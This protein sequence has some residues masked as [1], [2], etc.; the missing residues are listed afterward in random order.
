MAD[1]S[2]MGPGMTGPP[3][4]TASIGQRHI[5]AEALTARRDAA[6]LPRGTERGTDRV[7]LSDHARFLDQLGRMPAVRS[8]RVDEI[9]KAIAD[10]SYETEHRLMTALERLAQELQ[11]E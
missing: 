3:D 9:R 8:E 11:D 7:E 4:R 6:S 10:G 2:P 5:A 1:I